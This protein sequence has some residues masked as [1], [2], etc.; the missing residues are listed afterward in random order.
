RDTNI[1]PV[2]IQQS[3]QKAERAKH[4][5]EVS[6][7][8]K[9]SSSSSSSSTIT[10]AAS[11][12]EPPVVSGLQESVT[13]H[14]ETSQPAV[15]AADTQPAQSGGNPFLLILIAVVGFIFVVGAAIFVFLKSKGRDAVGEFNVGHQQE[16]YES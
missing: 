9:S 5:T 10:R 13:R 15:T 14:E 4:A 1:R 11:H 16:D 8:H 2:S 3:S 6:S 12:S 7:Q